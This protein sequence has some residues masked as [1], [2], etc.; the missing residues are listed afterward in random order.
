MVW[1]PVDNEKQK[2]S[3]IDYFT[4]VNTISYL[5]II[6]LLLLFINFTFT[7]T[8]GCMHHHVQDKVAH[9]EGHI[10][11]SAR[12]IRQER[13]KGFCKGCCGWQPWIHHP[14]L[15]CTC[16]NGST[17][18]WGVGEILGLEKLAYLQDIA[19]AI[20]DRFVFPLGVLPC[21]SGDADNQRGY[22]HNYIY[23]VLCEGLLDTARL[24][25]VREGDGEWII[26]HWR[27]DLVHFNVYNHPNYWLVLPFN[28][29]VLC[30][31][32]T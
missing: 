30:P 8:T 15:C 6:D 16:C 21:G 19:T 12:G 11:Q 27:Y 5:T 28:S 13:G 20:V 3:G 22:K 17:R 1:F 31:S 7:T 32:H 9:G 29:T 10:V 2:S 25:A 24:D 23:T 18:D 4:T 26:H 14:Q